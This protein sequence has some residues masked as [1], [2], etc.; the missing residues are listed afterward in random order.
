[1]AVD[2]VS[3]QTLI[4]DFIT[5]QEAAAAAEAASKSK[6]LTGLNADYD[7]FLKLLTAQLQY[8][9]PLAPTDANEYTKQLVSFSGV[10]QQIKANQKLDQLIGLQQGGALGTLLSYMDKYVEAESDYIPL[11]DG[12]GQVGY[13]L[14]TVAS[15]V[16]ITIKDKSGVTVATLDGPAT[17]GRHYVTW[18]GMNGNT[19]LPDGRY[20]F[21]ITAKDTDNKDILLKDVFVVGKVTSIANVEDGAVALFLG[22]LSLLDT[23]VA[24]LHATLQPNS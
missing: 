2:A 6:D 5:K 3:N 15:D 1:M 12:K 18:N 24:A 13:T 4:N 16:K 9:D 11:Q 22:D 10:E 21:E 19:Q 8:Q 17:V 23:K 14:P 20:E 7:T